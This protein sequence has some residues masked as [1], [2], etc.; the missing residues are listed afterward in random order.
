MNGGHWVQC[1][2]C[3]RCLINVSSYFSHP[4][5]IVSLLCVWQWWNW[6]RGR[7]QLWASSQSSLYPSLTDL[8][9]Q[10]VQSRTGHQEARCAGMIFCD[11]NEC[12][13]WEESGLVGRG[14]RERERARSRPGNKHD[15]YSKSFPLFSPD[16]VPNYGILSFQ[17]RPTAVAHP[18]LHRLLS[19]ESRFFSDLPA[20][21]M[22]LL[23]APSSVT[24]PY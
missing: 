17:T 14:G 1:L 8:C 12:E 23:P 20:S 10:A 6:D 19:P 7:P 3:S 18:T 15:H 22:S 5:V 13:A 21:M 4:L 11:E 9:P 16:P 2:T 24:N